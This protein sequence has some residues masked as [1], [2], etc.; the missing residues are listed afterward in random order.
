M[1]SESCFLLVMLVGLYVQSKTFLDS[2]FFSASPEFFN[3]RSHGSPQEASHVFI[4]PLVRSVPVCNDAY[5]CCST[6]SISVFLRPLFLSL[7]WALCLNF[8][9]PLS[10]IPSPNSLTHLA[11]QVSGIH[12]V[13][14]LHQVRHTQDPE[15]QEPQFSLH[16]LPLLP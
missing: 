4:I 14:F 16:L 3:R 5:P 15:G 9:A 1:A 12:F 13:L 2:I 6:R 11:V 8:A 7:L 10:V